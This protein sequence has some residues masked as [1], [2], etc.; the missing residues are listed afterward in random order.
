MKKVML[1]A[2]ILIASVAASA[3]NEVGKFSIAPTIGI[4]L[5]NASFSVSAISTSTK[6]GLVIGA[7]GEYG[8]LPTFSVSAALLYSM[9]GCKCETEGEQNGY[10]YKISEDVSLNYLNIPIMANY[11][12]W[13]GLAVKAGLQFGINLSSDDDYEM[14]VNGI[15]V[16]QEHI[17]EFSVNNVSSMKIIQKINV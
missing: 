11:Y 9:E 13:Q 5:S 15:A 4:N 16:P 14:T 1:V 3:Q 6:A 17:T 2:A 7:T 12:V 10:D 8:I